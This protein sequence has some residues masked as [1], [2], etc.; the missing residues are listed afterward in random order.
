[1]LGLPAGVV[2]CLFDLDG[3]LTDTALVHAAAWKATFDPV[4]RSL[5]TAGDSPY[6]PFDVVDDYRRYVDGRPR[7]EGVRS[8]LAARGMVLPEGAPGDPPS[9]VTVAGL[10]ERKNALLLA[11]LEA[12]PAPAYDGSIAYVRAARA[13]GLRCGVV[14][15]SANT[16]PVLASAG[17]AALF[18]VV[19]DG[20]VAATRGLRGKPAPDTFLAAA[21]LLDVPPAQAAV[22]EDALVGVQAGRAGGFGWVVGVDRAGQRA[23]L[24]EH[25]AD[26]VVDDLRE[27]LDAP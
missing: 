26:I 22:F 13:S 5:A 3:V 23:A 17:I 6:V 16:G 12:H 25:G 15:S 4:L 18:E 9:A 27:L 21:E 1:V 8:F 24:S 7:L 11:E 19:V 20:L 14:S 2:A 10:G